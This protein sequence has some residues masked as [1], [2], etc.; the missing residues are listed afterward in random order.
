MMCRARETMRR[1]EVISGRR[2]WRRPCRR[3]VDRAAMRSYGNHFGQLALRRKVAR[4]VPALCGVEA[5]VCRS[6]ARIENNCP[7]LEFVAHEVEIQGGQAPEVS[8]EMMTF[9]T[10]LARY[11]VGGGTTCRIPKGALMSGFGKPPAPTTARGQASGAG[12]E[13]MA[14]SA[15]LVRYEGG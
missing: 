9:S 8:F 5:E 3:A 1:F 14:F 15:P 11:G 2:R 10:F 13:K 6:L 12:F 7:S 4:D